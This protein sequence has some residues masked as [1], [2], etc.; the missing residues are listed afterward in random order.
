MKK[1]YYL[2]L[3]SFLTPL[4]PLAQENDIDDFW[5]HAQ[6]YEDDNGDFLN[7]SGRLHLDS[8]YFNNDQDSYT[9]ILWRRFRFG[10]KGKYKDVTASLEADLDLN[11]GAKYKRLTDANLSWQLS[12]NINFT[13]LKQSTGFTLDGKTSSKKLLTPQ[14]NNLTNNLWFTD[15]YF[16]GMSIKGNFA[17]NSSFHSGIFSSDN[18]DEIAFS[19]GSY[20][21][22]LS[23]K[24][25]IAKS[26]FWDKALV[27]F[28]Y[29]YN[30]V[31]ELGNTRNFTHI[32]SFSSNFNA[33]RWHLSTDFSLGMGDLEQSD[34]WGLVI[35][36]YYQQTAH[37]QWVARYTY[38]DSKQINGIK[39]GRYENKLADG[40]GDNYQELYA[41]I[42]YLFNQH[43][44]K[45]Q[46]GAQYTDMQDNANDGG[47]YSGWGLTLAVRSYW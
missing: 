29:V 31:N 3:L 7:L 43:K 9:D 22:L 45:L 21:A 40:K 30:D 1:I 38:L 11:D 32:T 24:S 18:S 28:D 2:L 44:L 26:R 17:Q 46:L 8:V 16:T 13:I 36:P 47:E 41:G 5:R 27:A 35:M 25:H 19:D 37:I 14:R 42:N 10:L 12:D 39:F 4:S 34:L 6:L 33:S 23:V 20:F 15:E